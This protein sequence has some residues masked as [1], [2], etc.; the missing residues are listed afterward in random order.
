MPLEARRDGYR[1]DCRV[2]LWSPPKVPY[3]KQLDCTGDQLAAVWQSWAL[4]A[5]VLPRNPQWLDVQIVS[6][7]ALLSAQRVTPGYDGE[8][9]GAVVEL[10]SNLDH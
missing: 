2:E 10:S 7:H 4:V 5:L 6:N 8:R 9:C 3:E 1:A